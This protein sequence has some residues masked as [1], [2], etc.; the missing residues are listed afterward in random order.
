M[1]GA[2][3][4]QGQPKVGHSTGWVVFSY[5]GTW[6][7]V[8]QEEVRAIA[9][10]LSFEADPRRGDRWLD[11]QRRWPAFRLDARLRRQAGPRRRFAIYV[12]SVPHPL[13]LLA[14]QVQI[15]APTAAHT[16]P[17]PPIFKAV[18]HP[19]AQ[20]LQLDQ[21]CIATVLDPVLLFMDWDD[22]AKEMMP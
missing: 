7:A 22:A 16:H 9:E 6:L 11:P 3:K 1:N 21:D 4:G 13:G 2:A 8:P 19:A 15:L 20:L 17:L 18:H 14:D 10:T 12:E 5:E